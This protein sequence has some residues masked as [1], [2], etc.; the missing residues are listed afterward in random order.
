MEQLR[1]QLE[2]ANK[3][4]EN[5]QHDYDLQLKKLNELANEKILL[6][7][8]FKQLQAVNQAAVREK[9]EAETR[10]EVNFNFTSTYKPYLTAYKERI[11]KRKRSMVYAS[12][13][14]PRD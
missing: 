1:G 8:Q 5:L 14:L 12:R 10:L 4:T 9:L 6:E 11:R 3:A 7:S 13:L 2:S